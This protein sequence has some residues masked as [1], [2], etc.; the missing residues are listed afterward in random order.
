[1]VGVGSNFF[2]GVVGVGF[3]GRIGVGLGRQGVAV[4]MGGF[5]AVGFEIHRVAVGRGGGVA[6]GLGG[7]NAEV[8]GKVKGRAV[9]V[10]DGIRMTAGCI[11][12]IGAVE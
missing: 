5:V 4:G 6:V 10:G 11:G 9:K 3:K 8:G 12:I 1:M 7:T 2:H